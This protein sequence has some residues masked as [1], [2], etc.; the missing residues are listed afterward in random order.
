MISIILCSFQT[1]KL[2]YFQPHLLHVGGVEAC[3]NEFLLQ[4]NSLPKSC[5][6]THQGIDQTQTP[7]AETKTGNI[8]SSLLRHFLSIFL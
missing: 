2:S 5:S 1:E 8:I 3:L 6:R 4:V 7:D